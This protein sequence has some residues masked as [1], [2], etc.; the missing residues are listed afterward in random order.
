[1]KEKHYAAFAVFSLMSI[2]FCGAFSWYLCA[3]LTTV[4]PC[5][6]V[7]LGVSTMVG[8]ALWVK[9][10]IWDDVF[11]IAGYFLGSVT[12]LCA[13]VWLGTFVAMS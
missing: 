3:D 8:M 11:S 1:M 13:V 9:G 5:M 4:F 2:V 10:Q 6:V 7:Y 12:S